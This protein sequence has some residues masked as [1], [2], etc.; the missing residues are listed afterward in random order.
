MNEDELRELQELAHQ[1]EEL[2]RHQGWG[3]LVDY[4][5][6]G[7]G[8]LGKHQNYLVAGNCKNPEEYQKYVGWIQGA[9]AVLSAPQ[10][11]REMSDKYSVGEI[12]E[13]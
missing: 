12:P 7:A 5:Q 3:I 1:L 8:M 9:M 13:Q 4:V 10:T 11:I 6:N 2:T